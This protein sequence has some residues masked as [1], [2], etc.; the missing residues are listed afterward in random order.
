MEP[1]GRRCLQTILIKFISV[2][3]YLIYNLNGNMVYF[4]SNKLVI[5]IIKDKMFEEGFY[6]E[7]HCKGVYKVYPVLYGEKE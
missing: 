1:D 7:K 2:L 4:I 3:I 5:S 6:I